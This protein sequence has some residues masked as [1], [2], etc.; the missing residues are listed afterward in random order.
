[1]TDNRGEFA[2]LPERVRA[3]RLEQF[4]PDGGATLASLL[5]VSQRRI[6]QLEIDDQTPGHFLLG[7]IEVT[8]ANPSWLLSGR[9]ERYRAIQPHDRVLGLRQN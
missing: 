2:S 6:A 1:M 4:G 8:G 7:F 3:I 9:G 5:G